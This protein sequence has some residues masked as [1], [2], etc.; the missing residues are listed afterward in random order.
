MKNPRVADGTERKHRLLIEWARRRRRF[1]GAVL[2]LVATGMTAVWLVVVP[3]EAQRGG[4]AREIAV[5]WGHPAC[6]ALLAV[7]GVLIAADAPERLRR[8]AAIA[9]AVCY[10]AFLAGLVL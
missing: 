4:G 10:V 5:R 9:A 1:L 7:V 3:E 6:W 8:A 2:A